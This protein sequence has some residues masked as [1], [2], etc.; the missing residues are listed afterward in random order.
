MKDSGTLRGALLGAAY[1]WLAR[2]DYVLGND[3]A[4]R[5]NIFVA[6]NVLKHWREKSN[7]TDSPRELR[8]EATVLVVQARHKNACES[9]PTDL[10]GQV[11]INPSRAAK[12]LL[13]DS[14]MDD[15]LSHP[16]SKWADDS[17]GQTISSPVPT[18][19]LTGAALTELELLVD[20]I[21][22]VAPPSSLS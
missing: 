9:R 18:T 1:L 5:H 20:R 4:G 16:V 12:K 15:T 3:E 11:E 19:L 6:R 10:D 14:G 8:L 7:P 13:F 17:A 2:L 22:E 21:V